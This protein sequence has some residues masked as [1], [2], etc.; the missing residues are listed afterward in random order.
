MTTTNNLKLAGLIGA[1]NG[2]AAVIQELLADVS[3]HGTATIKRAFGDR[4][5][6]LYC[7][8]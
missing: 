6:S 3:R 2:R 5:A 7:G 1:D 4:C 8:K